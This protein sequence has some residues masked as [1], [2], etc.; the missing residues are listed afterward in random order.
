MPII[1]AKLATEAL[2]LVVD[3]APVYFSASYFGEC[4]SSGMSVLQMQSCN[5]QLVLEG[6]PCGRVGKAK[7]RG[8]IQ[9]SR[10]H[11][12]FLKPKIRMK[13]RLPKHN[14]FQDLLSTKHLLSKFLASKRR[15]DNGLCR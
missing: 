14:S 9:K 8:V 15:V 4:E 10:C 7:A 1:E 6:V 5:G 3:E 11:T 12:T 2:M 13:K